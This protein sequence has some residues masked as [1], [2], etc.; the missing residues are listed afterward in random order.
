MSRARVLA[1]VLLAGGLIAGS[2][3]AAPPDVAPRQAEGYWVLDVDFHVHGFAG[4]GMLAPWALR[5]EVQRAG[6]EVFA[7]TNHNQTFTARAARR[8]TASTPGPIVIVGQEVTARDFH[9]SAVGIETPVNAEQTAAK[10]IEDIHAQGGIAIANHPESELYTRGYDHRAL[11]LLDG[12]ERTHPVLLSRPAAEQ[13]FEEFARRV[14][15]VN[16]DAALIG[17]S[18]FH[19]GGTPGWCRTY[20]LAR[21]R[22]AASVIEAVRDGRTV[23]A[24]ADGRLYGPADY[25]RIVNAAGGERKPET[26]DWRATVA[27]GVAWLGLLVLFVARP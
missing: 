20:V 15:A 14:V 1:L 26:N 2:V 12:F 6:I 17:S 25:V 5:R 22:T 7:L 19:G 4:D 16:R 8:L 10:V 18:D 11:A 23:A 27:A 9:I 24:D 13:S 21:E 3:G